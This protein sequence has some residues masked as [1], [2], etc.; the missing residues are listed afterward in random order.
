[1]THPQKFLQVLPLGEGKTQVI[2]EYYVHPS[3][4]S[5]PLTASSIGCLSGAL[6]SN[7][8]VLTALLPGNLLHAVFNMTACGVKAGRHHGF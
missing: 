8:T 4:V 3:K 1:M 5:F 6:G 2:M 7:M